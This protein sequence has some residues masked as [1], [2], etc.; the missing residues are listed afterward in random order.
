MKTYNYDIQ[1]VINSNVEL[2]KM[3]NELK[4]TRQEVD[5]DTMRYANC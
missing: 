3:I 1:R 2:E 5:F 4:G